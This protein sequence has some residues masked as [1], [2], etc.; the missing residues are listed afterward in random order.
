LTLEDKPVRLPIRL[1]GQSPWTIEYHNLNDSSGAQVHRKTLHQKNDFI[2]V[3]QQGVYKL[4]SVHDNACPGTV[5]Q[6]ASAFETSWI[7]RP[8]LEL[9]ENSVVERVGETYVK[10]EVCEGDED[11]VEVSLTG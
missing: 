3:R 8:H 9:S 1:I 4:V 7:E 6:A 5:E 10:K 2:E 11:T